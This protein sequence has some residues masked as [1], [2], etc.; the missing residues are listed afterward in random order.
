VTTDR[1]ESLRRLARASETLG[2]LTEY[3]WEDRK[4]VRY[5][6]P[7]TA[8]P[9][10]YEFDMVRLIVTSV[11][12]LSLAACETLDAIAALLDELEAWVA[13]EES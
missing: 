5:P 13:K 10:A 4:M 12:R 3:V 6:T 9:V 8:G 11:S 2:R 7:D 1:D